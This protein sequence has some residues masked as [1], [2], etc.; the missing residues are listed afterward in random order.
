MSSLKT[1]QTVRALLDTLAERGYDVERGDAMADRLGY[2]EVDAA[3]MIGISARK[4]YQLRSE[5]KIKAKK[6]GSR[7]IYSRGELIRFLDSEDE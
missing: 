4:L 2:S 6:I 3:M 5:G 1:Q 7:V